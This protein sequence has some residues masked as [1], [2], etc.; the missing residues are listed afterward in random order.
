M[1]N[2]FKGRWYFLSNDFPARVMLGEDCFPTV[3]HALLVAN[4][5][6]P[7]RSDITKIMQCGYA[8]MARRVAREMKSKVWNAEN[9]SCILPNLLSQKYEGNRLVNKLLETGSSELVYENQE[10]DTVLG[11]YKGY[12]LNLLGSL[13]M[14]ARSKYRA[15]RQG[16]EQPY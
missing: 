11:M 10:Q 12:G 2:Q 16:S 1:I 14:V 6:K 15:E 9:I 13:L 8:N 4:L 3:T 7:K 5:V